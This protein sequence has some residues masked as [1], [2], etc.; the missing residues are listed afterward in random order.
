MAADRESKGTESVI[1]QISYKKVCESVC[2]HVGTQPA[3]P[4]KAK[5]L[6]SSQDL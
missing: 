4:V 2:V 1:I 6:C 3:S 5:L